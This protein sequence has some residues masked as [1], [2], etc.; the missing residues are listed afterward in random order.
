MRKNSPQPLSPS[1]L[2]EGVAVA[3]KAN[4]L[5]RRAAVANWKANALFF[6]LFVFLLPDCIQAQPEIVDR[7]KYPFIKYEANSITT[8]NPLTLLP[9]FRSLERLLKSGDRQINIV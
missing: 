3:G 8:Y 1:P 7:V 9:V 2:G 4:A 6:L 5:G